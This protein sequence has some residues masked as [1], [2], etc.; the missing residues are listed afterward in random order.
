MNNAKQVAIAGLGTV[1]S[2]VVEGLLSKSGELKNRS[3]IELELTSVAE[4]ELPEGFEDM[5]ENVAHYE[6]VLT[7]LEEEK[8]DVFVELIGG[9]GV[10]RRAIEKALEAGLD[11]VTAN[12]ELLAKNGEEIFN[13]AENNGSRI[14]FEASVGGSIPVVRTIQKSFVSADF[15]EIYGIINGTANYVL[16]R[17]ENDGQKFSTALELAKDRGYAEADPTYDI[18]GDD[19]AHKL[20]IIAALAFGSRV[21]LENIY[22]EGITDI[23]PEI[24]D[25][26]RRLGYRIKLL[27]IAKKVNGGLDIR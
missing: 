17:M 8:P 10:A 13:I 18:E 5:F 15:T 12:K 9:V 20:A 2:E 27:G 6:D 7:L 25:D 23:S 14:R 16:S 4:P 26:A 1:G 11:V 21:P 19:S 24:I 22:C 3:G